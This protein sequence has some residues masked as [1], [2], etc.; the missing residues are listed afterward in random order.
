MEERDVH[1]VWKE[2]E[3]IKMDQTKKYLICNRKVGKA[4]SI[5]YVVLDPEFFILVTPCYDHTQEE[6]IDIILKRSLKTVEA[7]IDVR[8]D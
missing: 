6:K 8:R 4:M 2:G 1:K 3:K 7:Y 5:C